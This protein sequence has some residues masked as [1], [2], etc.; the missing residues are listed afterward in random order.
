MSIKILH[1]A[2]WHLGERKGPVRDGVNLRGQDTI[3]R[4]KEII[5]FAK[6][7]KPD[8]VLMSGDVIDKPD[9]YGKRALKDE[10]D[11]E[12]LLSELAEYTER[13]IVIRGTPN[14]DGAEAFAALNE[15]FKK[16]DTVDIV[17]TPTVIHTPN[18]DVAC[19]PGFDRGV[20]R[21]AYP[22][23]PKEKEAEVFSAELGNI[24]LGLKGMCKGN[25]PSVLMAHYY[26][27]GTDTGSGGG[28]FIQK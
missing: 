8:I 12:E 1:C 15:H 28:S 19:L 24:V 5:E 23:V 14:H 10:L 3:D 26:V 27:P 9:V 4:I 18:L 16:N 25:V 11:A 21:A 6:I 20:F 13:M 22:D 17:T 2:D 7:A